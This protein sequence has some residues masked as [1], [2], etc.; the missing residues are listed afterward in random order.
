M[1][2][3]TFRRCLARPTDTW[4]TECWLTCGSD[5]DATRA[6]LYEGKAQD[7][8]E[9]IAA[10]YIIEDGGGTLRKGKWS[11]GLDHADWTGSPMP[12]W[13][14]GTITHV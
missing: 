6:K 7:A 12:W 1:R 4:S 5:D 3:T 13:H 8:L 2:T 14:W 11:S 10:R 9:K